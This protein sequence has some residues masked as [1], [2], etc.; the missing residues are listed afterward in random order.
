MRFFRQ[1]PVILGQ[2]LAGEIEAAG[3]K[4][5]R[6]KA[7]DQVTGWCG[8]HLGGYAE[9]ACL[10]GNVVMAL[11][12]PTMSYEEATTIPVGGLDATY[13]IRKAN[14]RTG[15]RVLIN[16]AGGC[17]GTYAVQIAKHYG[18]IVTAVDSAPKLDM[19]RSIGADHVIDYTKEHFT[20]RRETYDVIFDVVGKSPFS[21]AVKMLTPNGRFLSGNGYGQ[22]IR[23][24]WWA[25]RSGKPFIPW[26]GRSAGQYADDFNFLKELFEAGKVKAVVDRCFPLEQ[27]AAA[28]RYVESGQKK[29]HVVITVG[30]V[31]GDS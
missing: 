4:V 6:F 20:G 25:R 1:K 28:H 21:R 15:E 16:G 26:A 19:L 13:F 10:P 27:T 9:Y 8:L 5:T 17:I 24:R 3:N 11:K 2:E 30:Q 7:G 18:A 23:G 31:R 14:I 22:L 12:P 29:G